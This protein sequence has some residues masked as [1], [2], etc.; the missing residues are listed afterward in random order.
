MCLFLLIKIIGKLER[1]IEK[2]EELNKLHLKLST[3]NWK[4]QNGALKSKI[5]LSH[6]FLSEIRRSTA[7]VRCLHRHL[8]HA[9]FEVSVANISLS[10]QHQGRRMSSLPSHLEV[11]AA[12]V[13]SSRPFRHNM[14][15]KATLSLPILSFC[16][17]PFHL[18]RPSGNFVRTLTRFVRREE[19]RIEGIDGEL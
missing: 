18:Y 7:A 2:R 16:K 9:A 11:L 1:E 14:S 12:T 8:S 10:P 6:I 15:N 4:P 5:S 19:F 13:W 17:P 3:L